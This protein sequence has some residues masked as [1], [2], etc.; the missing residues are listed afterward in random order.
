MAAVVLKRGDFDVVVLAIERER[1]VA[2]SYRWRSTA[3]RASSANR[4]AGGATVD[5]RHPFAAGDGGVMAV[6]GGVEESISLPFVAMQQDDGVLVGLE[7]LAG[8]ERV[9]LVAGDL[10]NPDFGID[11]GQALVVRSHSCIR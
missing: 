7:S 5:G 1:E 3:G 6:A 10:G 11:A 9:A 4:R 8:R 2:G